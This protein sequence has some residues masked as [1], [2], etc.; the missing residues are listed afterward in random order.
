MNMSDFTRELK[1]GVRA[2]LVLG[3]MLVALF[4]L[5]FPPRAAAV[6]CV[7]DWSYWTAVSGGCTSITGLLSIDTST[8]LTNLD[9]LSALTSVGGSL[10]LSTTTTR[11]PTSTASPR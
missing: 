4:V 8:A 9:G 10:S 6:E 11:S 1:T 7:G 2:K 5:L 3:I